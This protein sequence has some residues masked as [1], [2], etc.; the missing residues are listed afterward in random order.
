MTVI[1]SCAVQA[2]NHMSGNGGDE[3]ASGRGKGG[4]MPTSELASMPWRGRSATCPMTCPLLVRTGLS[5]AMGK[6]PEEIRSAAHYISISDDK[7]GI[8]DAIDA[9]LLPL[10]GGSS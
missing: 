8:A 3:F 6:A 10:V 2:S 7:D 5:I 4:P 9:F 1:G